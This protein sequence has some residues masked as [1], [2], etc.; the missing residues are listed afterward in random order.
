MKLKF[1]ISPAKKSLEITKCIVLILNDPAFAA[2][3]PELSV[4]ELT[5]ITAK[6]VRAKTEMSVD[7]TKRTYLNMSLFDLKIM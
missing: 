1:K 3:Q 5:G 7:N 4:W 2:A 6:T